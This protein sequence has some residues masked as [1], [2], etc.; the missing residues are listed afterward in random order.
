VV[1]FF[2]IIWL[3][4]KLVV[5]IFDEQAV[6]QDGVKATIGWLGKWGIIS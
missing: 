6:M 4:I 5:A 3:T 1:A 2:I